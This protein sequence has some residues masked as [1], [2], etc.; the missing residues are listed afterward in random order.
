METSRTNGTNRERSYGI[1]TARTELLTIWSH[2]AVAVRIYYTGKE[3][4][5]KFERRI[6]GKRF[7][8][9]GCEFYKLSERIAKKTFVL[10]VELSSAQSIDSRD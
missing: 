3:P 10:F 4:C 8:Q 6:N 2:A 7:V 5:S 9:L 1:G